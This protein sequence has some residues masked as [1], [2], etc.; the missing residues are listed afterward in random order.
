M[1]V[2][3][4]SV[5]C[6]TPSLASMLVNHFKFRQDVESYSLGGMSCSTGV[7]G[8]GLIKNLLAVRARSTASIHA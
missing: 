4:C 3:A 8:V 6:P 5:Y 7:S 1:L 2:T